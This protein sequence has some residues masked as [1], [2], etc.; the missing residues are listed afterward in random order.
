MI[1]LVI[2]LL[3]G[4]AVLS[5]LWP[6]S[7]PAPKPREDVADVAFY[8]AQIAEIDADLSRGVLE[9]D[10]AE[11][12]KALAARR[13]I[14]AAP[15]EVATHESA[16]ARR[17]AAVVALLVIP[18]VG[19]GL[20]AKIGRPNLP[21]MP[22]QARLD[23]KPDK[24]DFAALV[25]KMEA[26]IAAH[27][28][29][30]RAIELMAPV[31]LRLGKFQKAVEARKKAI[32]LLGDTAERRTKYAIALAF[33]AGGVFTPDAEDQLHHALA[34]DHNYL[35]AQYYLGLAAA[36]HD[37]KEE[38]RKIWTAMLSELPAKSQARKTVEQK[39]AMLDAPVANMP[40]GAAAAAVAAEAPEQQQKTIRA[41]VARLADR[42]ATKGGR[43]DEWMRL[44]RAYKVL[45]E[46]DKAQKA[47][48][49]AKKALGGDAA[50]Q[51]QLAALA[52]QLGLA[53]K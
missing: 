1:W 50:A 35:E 28:D 19:L 16:W 37:Q 42:L 17:I 4:L 33:A 51:T 10:Q 34:L 13:L 24:S 30:G 6:L 53:S 39:L 43:P 29:D 44:I 40:S 21:D 46:P 22:L 36:Q 49:E 23:A 12:A 18:A 52:Q 31:Y 48:G 45:N 7:R 41:M 14:A 5:I 9:K 20:Y 47:L 38:A 8:R 26:H 27:P 25:E 11:A 2:A 15:Q 32:K 3:T